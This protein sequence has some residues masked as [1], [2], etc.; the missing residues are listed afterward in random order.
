MGIFKMDE[1]Y[2]LDIVNATLSYVRTCLKNGQQ[3]S[4]LK[5]LDDSIGVL[6]KFNVPEIAKALIALKESVLIKANK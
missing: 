5:E 1:A 4:A 6:F 2:Y 3:E